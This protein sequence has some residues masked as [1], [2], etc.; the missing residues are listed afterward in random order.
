MR[1]RAQAGADRIL[2]HVPTRCGE[3]TVVVEYPRVEAS[4]EEMACAGVAPVEELSVDAVEALEASRQG[5]PGGRD[6]E[7]I[8][9]PH[10]AERVAAP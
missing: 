6:D 2:E 8:V 4:A 9:R 5:L 3:V 7:V 1:L 10:E